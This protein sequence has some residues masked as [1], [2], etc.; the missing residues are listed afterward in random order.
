MLSVYVYFYDS[1]DTRQSLVVVWQ[2]Q[3]RKA[4][5]KWQVSSF[6]IRVV[7]AV[8]VLTLIHPTE[9]TEMESH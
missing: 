6:L 5:K 3:N 2:N 7:C 9:K 1:I 8:R 4:K